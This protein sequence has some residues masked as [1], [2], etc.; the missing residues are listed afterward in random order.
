VKRSTS[1]DDHECLRWRRSLSSRCEAE[2][3]VSVRWYVVFA[4]ERAARS[5]VRASSAEDGEGHVD[6][7]VHCET[8]AHAHSDSQLG[9]PLTRTLSLS[10]SMPS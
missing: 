9:R 7:S 8:T 4:V 5:W 2:A 10:L 1:E 3:D 6:P